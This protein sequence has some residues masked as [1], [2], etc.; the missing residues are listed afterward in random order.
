MSTPPPIA[1]DL[2]AIARGILQRDYDHLSRL[3]AEVDESG[4]AAEEAYAEEREAHRTTLASLRAAESARAAQ[5]LAAA[6][7]EAERLKHD[8]GEWKAAT[9][10]VKAWLDRTERVAVA[11]G[12]ERDQLRADL[13]A[14]EAK[15]TTE[16][17][18][19]TN[20]IGAKVDAEEL[21]AERLVDQDRLAE[22]EAE[23]KELRADI[24]RLVG[25]GEVLR[26]EAS[27]SQAGCTCNDDPPGGV[28]MGHRANCPDEE[29]PPTPAERTGIDAE[30][31]A[32]AFTTA[33]R[34]MVGDIAPRWVD[35]EPEKRA[36]KI[37]QCRRALVSVGEAAWT[38]TDIQ[39]IVTRARDVRAKLDD[40]RAPPPAE[41][42]RLVDAYGRSRDDY[43]TVHSR[44]DRV[45]KRMSDEAKTAL[46]SAISRALS[47]RPVPADLAARP[48][49]R[50]FALAMEAK[51]RENDHR[52]G[53]K[54]DD[55]AR[56][57]ERL[58]EEADEVGELLA[59]NA[60]RLA[61][62][63]MLDECA[64]VANFA[65]MIADVCGGL[66]V[67]APAS[68]DKCK[69]CGATNA[70]W[71]GD[72]LGA[73]MGRRMHRAPCGHVCRAVRGYPGK[74]HPDHCGCANLGGG[75]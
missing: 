59:F 30:K 40:L 23:V 57:L 48:E 43:H 49:V 66:A 29:W 69:L 21:A 5:G 56:L 37:E 4:R 44:E 51:L 55:P 3:Y 67:E 18:R 61:P 68:V 15:L 12:K 46:L 73:G 36:Q 24:A 27:S 70:P 28:G 34:D 41:I 26:K 58:R 13:A 33:H 50:A 63:D 1:A 19:A 45:A 54:G 25:E 8:I 11:I 7:A 16:R 52:P 53:W 72:P 9:E 32:E 60:Y 64:D 74:V 31:L 39:G 22:L 47:A 17:I 2:D 65:M 71:E 38:E 35:L 42:E 62:R 6:L 75:S 20:A 14:S 10:A